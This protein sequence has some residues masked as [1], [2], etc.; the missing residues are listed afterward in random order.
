MASARPSPIAAEAPERGAGEG[1]LAGMSEVFFRASS[2]ESRNFSA[3]RPVRRPGSEDSPRPK[4]FRS[5]SDQ[6]GTV[7]GEAGAVERRTASCSSFKRRKAP[8]RTSWVRAIKASRRRESACRASKARRI[9]SVKAADDIPPSVSAEPPRAF[10]QDLLH[11][12]HLIQEAMGGF[13]GA[14]GVSAVHG[15]LRAFQIVQHVGHLEHPGW[16]LAGRR[17]GQE[18]RRLSQALGQATQPVGDLC[19]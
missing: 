14:R 6:D 1:I 3:R 4:T 2:K 7:G 13:L 8:S 15:L 5:P 17:V 10:G 12:A 11:L 19:P 18:A 16:V 9:S